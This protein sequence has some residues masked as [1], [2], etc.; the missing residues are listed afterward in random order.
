LVPPFSSASRVTE[1]AVRR[2]NDSERGAFDL[3]FDLVRRIGPHHLDR[4]V[5]LEFEIRDLGVEQPQ[6]SDRNRFRSDPCTPS[7]QDA[8]KRA[9]AHFRVHRR[10]AAPAPICRQ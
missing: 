3:G 10:R 5:E 1:R 9:V 4:D 2:P 7:T 8:K 6:C